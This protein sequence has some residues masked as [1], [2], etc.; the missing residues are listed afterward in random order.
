MDAGAYLTTLFESIRDNVVLWTPRILL[1]LV[2][3]VL[4][5]VVSR[6]IAR[7][8]RTVLRRIG[9]DA[10]LERTGVSSTLARMGVSKPLSE[11]LSRVAYY[12][13]L[14]LFVRT[15]ADAMGLDP[16]SSAIGTFLAYLPNVFAA[17]VLVLFGASA[18]QV[19]SGVV[20]RAAENSGIEFA[21]P[22][23][24]M[25]GALILTVVGLMA[26]AQLRVDTQIVYLVVSGIMAGLVLA[27]GLSFGLGSRDIA[28]NIL[29]GFYARRSLPTG[30]DLQIGDDRGRLLGVGPTQ[31]LLG[32]EGGTTV[33]P[34]TVFLEQVVRLHA[35]P[36]TPAG[37][38]GTP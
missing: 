18:A 16:I 6:M 21:K 25:V 11:V 7:V 37:P 8:L 3:F 34:N 5:L 24:R 14:L 32:D 30:A 29:A 12:L 27:L 1:G 36:D 2:L 15:A 38:A 17:V 19:A 9:L 20:T 33:V 23:G 26:V 31:T 4:A 22:L 28:R 35:S 13:I 10:L